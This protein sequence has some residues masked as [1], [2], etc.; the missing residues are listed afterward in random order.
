[1]VPSVVG[2]DV[3]GLSV[4]EEPVMPSV[5]GSVMIPVVLVVPV[6]GG[7]SSEHPNDPAVTRLKNNALRFIS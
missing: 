6:V 5:S 4:V 7:E 3:V 1:M 2:P